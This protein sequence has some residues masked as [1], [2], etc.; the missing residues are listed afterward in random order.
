MGCLSHKRIPPTDNRES[1]DKG[2]VTLVF[3]IN[4]TPL[5]SV[6][7]S[8]DLTDTRSSANRGRGSRRLRKMWPL[9]HNSGVITLISRVVAIVLTAAEEFF[10]SLGVHNSIK[11][12]NVM[13]NIREM[14]WAPPSPSPSGWESVLIMT[15]LICNRTFQ[16]GG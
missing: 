12:I 7:G 16:L 11:P 13:M 5:L 15:L 8:R 10:N 6:S 14:N 3:N 2:E 1:M 9:F 4:S